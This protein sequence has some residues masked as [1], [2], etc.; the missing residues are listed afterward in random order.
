MTKYSL[1]LFAIYIS[2]ISSQAGR[3]SYFPDNRQVIA[4]ASSK[5][6]Q[7]TQR[8][9]RRFK[10]KKYGWFS[11][12]LI[13]ASILAVGVGVGVVKIVT[14][15]STDDSIDNDANGLDLFDLFDLDKINPLEDPS[16]I[17]LK[18]FVFGRA[19][20]I[21]NR[22]LPMITPVKLEEMEF[23]PDFIAT[24]IELPSDLSKYKDTFDS[25]V[26]RDLLTLFD[27]ANYAD[28]FRFHLSSY[29]SI[30]KEEAR[31]ILGT[32]STEMP[33]PPKNVRYIN[34]VTSKLMSLETD[35]DKMPD[36]EKA[37]RE[38]KAAKNETTLQIVL[39]N[40]VMMAK[41]CYGTTE[42]FE[43]DISKHID[44]DSEKPTTFTGDIYLHAQTYKKTIADR[45]VD[46]FLIDK[47]AEMWLMTH[48]DLEKT[49]TNALKKAQKLFYHN[50]FNGGSHVQNGLLKAIETKI[51]LKGQNSIT[52]IDFKKWT[53]R[54]FSSVNEHN[55]LSGDMLRDE[56]IRSY[57][58]EW[59]NV[60]AYVKTLAKDILD[61]DDNK[62]K[63]Q[64]YQE[65]C[66]EKGINDLSKLYNNTYDMLNSDML[67]SVLYGMGVLRK[68]IDGESYKGVL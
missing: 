20:H 46:K 1:F 53:L 19:E 64:H 59:M 5:R 7:G 36:K 65:W 28:S 22:K 15:I 8:A 4:N 49:Q 11:Y 41:N 54:Y 34:M 10:E 66:K 21:W 48:S 60:E 31:E 27:R 25:Q 52:R 61:V 33:V 23:N 3:I 29:S 63:A 17:V 47:W 12:A 50:F 30:S 14:Q 68:K 51:G 6:R 26:E 39:E 24:T 38:K 43:Q 32:F 40:Y 57:Y 45:W 58:M 55:Y 42:Q 13:G 35:P 16:E 44:V 9:N 18:D 2:S 62:V 67:A 37:E 56:F